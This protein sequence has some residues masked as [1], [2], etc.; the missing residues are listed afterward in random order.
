MYDHQKSK[1]VF[2]INVLK[3][4]Y[5]APQPEGVNLTEQGDEDSL[6]K[7]FPS[8]QPAIDTLGAPTLGKQLTRPQQNNLSGLMRK[9]ADVFST[10]PELIEHH[11]ETSHT[12]PIKL[13]TIIQSTTSFSG[14]G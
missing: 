4:W 13:R 12:K 7:D 11:I 8:W 14:N 5:P 6:D 10:K 3:K 2:H 1:H 9:F